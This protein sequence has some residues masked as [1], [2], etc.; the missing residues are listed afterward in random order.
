MSTIVIEYNSLQIVADSATNL[1]KRAQDYADELSKKVSKKISAVPGGDSSYLSSANYMVNQKITQL[2]SK[3]DRFQKY[4]G[5]IVSLSE[6]AR[7]VDTNVKNAIYN[8][9]E[10]FM[11]SEGI[12]VPGWKE[13]IISWLVDL[14]NKNPVFNMICDIIDAIGNEA[15]NLLD[16]IRYWYKC[17]G[18]KEKV[19]IVVAVG[20]AIVA[21]L[22]FVA[23]LPALTAISGVM[24]AIFAIAG[25]IGAAIGVVN[26]ITNVITSV[27]AYDAKKN[28]DDAWAKI[29]GDTDTLSDKIRLHNFGSSQANGFWN[30]FAGAVDVIDTVCAV[31]GSIEGITKIASKLQFVKNYFGENTGLLAYMKEAKWGEFTYKDPLTG[32]WSVRASMLVDDHGN[33]K[34]HYTP[35]SILNG[36]KAYITDSGAVTNDGTGLRTLLNQNL[37][38]D[39]KDFKNSFTLTGLKDTIRYQFTE[40]RW[41]AWLDGA[42]S[43]DTNAALKSVNALKSIVSDFKI[44]EFKDFENFKNYANVIKGGTKA[45][46]GLGN[47]IDSGLE[48]NIDIKT[49]LKEAIK[50]NTVGGQ[51]YGIASDIGDGYNKINSTIENSFKKPVTLTPE[52]T[53]IDL[54][55][56][57]MAPLPVGRLAFA[58]ALY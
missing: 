34:T 46:A 8:N 44:G 47:F 4:S 7:R 18:G 55:V 38:I 54:K 51:I 19:Q 28:G 13:A 20:L 5:K 50:A 39:F 42:G 3:A 32:E 16:N 11:K 49:N 30:G 29:H 36:L 56:P 48:I 15:S 31:I 25:V 24:S 37:K 58:G 9:Q 53:N 2:K 26:A 27:A 14:K 17:E 52:L 57:K 33:V 22:L 6:T 45:I 10:A 43:S 41:V 23:A 12:E 21:V 1:A 40:N 35:R